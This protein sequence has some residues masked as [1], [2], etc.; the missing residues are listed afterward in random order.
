MFKKYLLPLIIALV[1]GAADFYFTLP[2]INI[3]SAGFW[4]L[5]IFMAVVY[6]VSMLI[7]KGIFNLKSFLSKQPKIEDIEKIKKVKLKRWQ[8]YAII[9]FVGI[10]VLSVAVIVISSSMLFNAEKYQKML[11]VKD[12]DF[13]EVIAE[14]PISKI[15]IVDKDSAERLGSRKIGEVVELVSQFNVSGYYTQ[16]NYD[17]KPY[18]VSPLE[19]ADF[20]KWCTNKNQGI[21]YYVKID[22][23][24][25]NTELVKLAEGMKYTP[26]EYFS[27]D[28]MRH[29]RFK[30]PTKMFH[31][32]SFEI[33]D[34]GKPYWMIS[35]YDY[36]IGFLGGKD[37]AGI[38]CV[39]AITGETTDYKV[40]EV[41]TWVDRVYDADIILEQAASWGK[42]TEGYWNSVFGQKNVI[43]TTDGYNYIALND[44]VWLFTGITS[45]VSDE[46]NIGFILVNMRT[47]ESMRFSIN[48]AEEYSAMS[49]AQGKIQEKGYAATFPILVNVAD[50]PSYF[51]SLKD[52]AGLVK[53]Y[54]FVSVSNYQIVG[55][56]DTIE[57]ASE[58]YLKL[59]KSNGINLNE[60]ADNLKGGITEEITIDRIS[61][62]VV[63]GNSIYYIKPKEVDKI[64]TASIDISDKLPLLMPGDKITITRKNEETTAII[65]IK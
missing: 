41:P 13:T 2:A 17:E 45:V 12:G 39:D 26:S 63:N 53:A 43:A 28:L 4:G 5:L 56:G 55:V 29:V 14:L 54:S 62:A 22:M 48:G 10:V 20:I 59:L 46:S 47:K 7:L 15:P 3:K 36:T 23:A 50:T 32:T 49:S 61:S 1:F 19:Y 34:S 60:N 30:Y 9:G 18:R 65:N 33:D 40:N 52:N 25:Q 58:E 35:Y 31:S 64:Y 6:V 57:Q 24:T 37:I 38:I 44:D 51:I 21:P 11:D 8:K 27:R 42:F 16:I